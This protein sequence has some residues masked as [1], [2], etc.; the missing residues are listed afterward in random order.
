MKIERVTFGKTIGMPNYGN[1]RPGVEYAILED[2]ETMEH[3]LTELNQRIIEWHKKEYPHLYG[4]ISTV[5]EAKPPLVDKEIDS[6]LDNM[7]KL[8]AD[9]EFKED[10]ASLIARSEFKFNVELKAIAYA[11]PNKK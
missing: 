5:S 9:I 10:A 1:D 8:L 7:R 11:K 4:N 3:A 2:G 6:K